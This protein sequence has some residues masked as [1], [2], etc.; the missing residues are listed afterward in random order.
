MLF[1]SKLDIHKR[2]YF[3]ELNLND[4][5]PLKKKSKVFS[6]LAAFPSSERD[7]TVTLKEN[8]PIA[9][10]TQAIERTKSPS[11]E[12]FYLLD[13]YT[14]DQLGKDRKNA[15]FRFCYRDPSKTLAFEVI[16]KEHHKLTHSVA[17][18]LR[19]CIL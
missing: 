13:L 9:S 11:L 8:V 4:I 12:S 16:E 10:V 14:S 19:D 7:W 3:A 18:K 5:L 6:E 1:R 17:E 2:V 15:T